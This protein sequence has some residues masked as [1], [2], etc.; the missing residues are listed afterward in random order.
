MIKT[1]SQKNVELEFEAK[2]FKKVIASKN[3]EIDLL[4][5]ELSLLKKN[6]MMLNPGSSIFEEIQ[7]AG[8]RNCTGL[9]SNGS[10]SKGKT[11]FV[12]AKTLND[13]ELTLQVP[14]TSTSRVES[15]KQ[16]QK[17]KNSMS[18][19]EIRPLPT[20]SICG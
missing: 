9:G 4:K 6:V 1:L 14:D 11:V 15:S 19:Q 10:Q 5:K 12:P 13:C 8:Q 18:L 20:Y 7:N 2:V 16:V 3:S 17:G